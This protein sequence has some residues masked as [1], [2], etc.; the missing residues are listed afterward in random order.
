MHTLRSVQ[1]ESRMSRGPGWLWDAI[2]TRFDALLH[3]GREEFMRGVDGDHAQ[4]SRHGYTYLMM[5]GAGARGGAQ[6][7][8][9]DNTTRGSVE[10]RD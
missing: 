8:S 7:L 10:E 4:C 6:G 1:D 9:R 5:G 3:A 2:V